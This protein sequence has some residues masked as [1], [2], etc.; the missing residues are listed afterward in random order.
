MI[1]KYYY[2]DTE[3][4]KLVKNM[5]ILVDT[6]EKVNDHILNYFD[7][8]DIKYKKKSLDYGDYSFMLK[9]NEKLGIPKDVWFDKLVVIERKS[10][11]KEI[12]NNLTSE[13]SRFEKE[14]ALAPKDKVILIENASY[15]D[16]ALGNYD[17][18]YNYNLTTNFVCFSIWALAFTIFFNTMK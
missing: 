13:R 16:I 10:S 7:K 9:A 18:K 11:L 17:T 12:S 1:D 14:L 6:K 8:K 4:K 3:I 2:T 5:V 15:E